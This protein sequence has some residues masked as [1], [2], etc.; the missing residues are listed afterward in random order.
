MALHVTK[1]DTAALLLGVAQDAGQPPQA[2]PGPQLVVVELHGREGTDALV[3][4]GRTDARV[5][6]PT[7][8]PGPRA[9]T[10]SR[11]GPRRPGWTEEVGERPAH[12]WRP[13][14]QERKLG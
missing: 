13:R 9:S 11:C 12:L 7:C 10:C 8:H 5:R 3:L 2:L 14:P 4:Q 6:P 1:N